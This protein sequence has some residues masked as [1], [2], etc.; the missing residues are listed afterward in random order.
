MLLKANSLKGNK[1]N[2]NNKL[3]ITSYTLISSYDITVS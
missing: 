1:P 2:N 3:H